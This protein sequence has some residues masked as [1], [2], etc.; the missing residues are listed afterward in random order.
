MALIDKFCT[1]D[2]PAGALAF[3]VAVGA[4]AILHAAM[5]FAENPVD[6]T[7]PMVLF[8][9]VITSSTGNT[10]LQCVK[11]S[12][13]VVVRSG[14]CRT[15]EQP[16]SPTVI[17]ATAWVVKDSNGVTVGKY[18]PNASVA[19]VSEGPPLML[20]S[21]TPD[22]FAPSGGAFFAS[23]DCSGPALLPPDNSHGFERYGASLDVT[24][25]RAARVG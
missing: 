16:L 24:K 1:R 21:V 11:R 6:K 17:G 23:N 18:V 2:T 10:Q 25:N 13:V 5:A 4:V 3:R 15:R 19:A 14:S 12:G 9:K 22:G 20:V 7:S 8:P